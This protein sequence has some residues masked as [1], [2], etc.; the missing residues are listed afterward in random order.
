MNQLKT[1]GSGLMLLSLLLSL[2]TPA[3]ARSAQ[4]PLYQWQTGQ[5]RA[6]MDA[7]V[8]PVTRQ[9][10]PA[11]IVVHKS[12]GDSRIIDAPTDPNYYP[13]CSPEFT[14]PTLYSFCVF[15]QTNPFF[16]PTCQLTDPTWLPQCG[17]PTDPQFFQDC[18]TNPAFDPFCEDLTNP[19]IHPMCATNP[20]YDPLCVP[21]DPTH[22][23]LCV[24]TDPSWDSS[25]I[26]ADALDVPGTFELGQN[27]PNPFNP[28]T[29][30]DFTLSETSMVTL[31]V[32][33]L[34][35]AHVSTLV[36]GMTGSGQHSVELD[37]SRLASGVYVY[38]L[39]ANDRTLSRKMVLLK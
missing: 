23:P 24:P 8:V 10:A 7:G 38:T 14:N 29:R 37:A 33:D 21:T 32:F 5:T 9:Q 12:N 1:F 2:N 13:V 22:D 19:N 11:A 4:S 6:R 17:V 20:Q 3:T 30:I 36:H 28:V 16:L 34:S 15:S 31:A 35:G 18:Q 25:C 27:Y 39:Q 26:P